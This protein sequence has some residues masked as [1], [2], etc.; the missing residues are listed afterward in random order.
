MRASPRGD[1]PARPVTAYG[2]SKLAGEQAVRES[3]PGFSIVRPPMVYGPGDTEFL[4]LFRLVRW[5]FSPVFGGG[6]QELSAVYGPDLAEALAATATTDK[7]LGGIYYACHAERFSSADFARAIGRA[8]GCRI[9]VVPLSAGL[10][11]GLLRFT[12]SAARVVGKTTVLDRDKA[13]ELLAPAWTGDPEPLLRDA[14]WR[15]GHDLEAGLAATADWY[16]ERGLV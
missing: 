10:T 12:G 9:R 2:R 15:A 3:A 1:E 5:G 8:M 11:R 4:R 16:R 7:T 6:D 14:G 13:N